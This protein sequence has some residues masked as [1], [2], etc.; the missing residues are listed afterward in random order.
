MRQ[1]PGWTK[2]P[3]GQDDWRFFSETKCLS[4]SVSGI[5]PH[6]GQFVHLFRRIDIFGEKGQLVPGLGLDKMS[7]SSE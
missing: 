4:S 3:S 2:C 5:L 1:I 7:I 6:H